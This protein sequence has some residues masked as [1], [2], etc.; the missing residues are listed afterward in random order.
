MN[1]FIGT[2]R[3]LPRSDVPL[4]LR[5]ARTHHVLDRAPQVFPSPQGCKL[6]SAR[7]WP[8]GSPG[9]RLWLR[10]GG[11]TQ[12][13]RIPSHDGHPAL[14]AHRC[15]RPPSSA[16]PLVYASPLRGCGGTFTRKR[17]ALLGAQPGLFAND[18]REEPP[19]HSPVL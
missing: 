12:A 14:R 6:G 11:S 3:D 9:S 13:L 19:S 7:S 1:T 10:P 16:R 2:Q 18:E 17:I 4:S 8:T 5:A 15:T